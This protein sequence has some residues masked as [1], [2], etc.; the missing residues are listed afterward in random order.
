MDLQPMDACG[1]RK[2]AGNPEE[3]DVPKT[4]PKATSCPCCGPREPFW[5]FF[6]PHPPARVKKRF[7]PPC[8]PS[9]VSLTFGGVDGRCPH[10]GPPLL[11]G[12]LSPAGSHFPPGRSG[13]SAE[14]SARC[15]PE[16]PQ[17]MAHC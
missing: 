13:R 8:A 3:L 12:S 7:D 17:E 10:P 15:L 11:S 14:R 16:P 2:N 6:F 5:L 1:P 9:G 4:V